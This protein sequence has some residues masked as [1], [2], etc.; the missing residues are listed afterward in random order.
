MKPTQADIVERHAHHPPTPE[1]V[2]LH[3]EIRRQGIDFALWL[4]HNLPESRELSLAL[5]AVQ[6]AT[7][8]ANA[9]V[10]IHVS[11]QQHSNRCPAC[12]GVGNLPA[13]S[14][15]LGICIDCDGTGCQH[16]GSQ[17][18]GNHCALCEQDGNCLACQ[19]ALAQSLPKPT[20]D[21]VFDPDAMTED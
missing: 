21:E 11:G 15:S 19:R 2:G 10:A 6:E 14:F 1:A 13:P 12:K 9:A 17:K 18:K 20:E 8:W 3:E 16:H 4:N 5:T 7:M